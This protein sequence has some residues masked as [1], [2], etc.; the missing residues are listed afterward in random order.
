MS[1]NKYHGSYLGGP[2]GG[3]YVT[4]LNSNPG[5]GQPGDQGEA[6]PVIQIHRG[7]THPGPGE[8][9]HLAGH[10]PVQTSAIEMG[11]YKD[12]HSAL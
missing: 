10:L 9:L 7:Q 12:Y 6:P 1:G 4:F 2:G 11:N 3:P 5:Y 8:M